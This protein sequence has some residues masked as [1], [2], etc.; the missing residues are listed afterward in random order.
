MSIVYE[1]IGRLWVEFARR[2]YAREIRIAALFGVG[3]AAL[4]AIGAYAATRPSDEQD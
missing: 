1:M 4:A 2:H 3:I